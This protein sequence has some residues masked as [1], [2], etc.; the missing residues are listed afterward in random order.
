MNLSPEQLVAL[1]GL[2]DV[3]RELRQMDAQADDI[4]TDRNRAIQRALDAGVPKS[5]VA[6]A[7]GVHRSRL[8][9]LLGER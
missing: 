2:E 7:A 5:K 8:Y 1:E 6:A 4:R 9:A 3:A